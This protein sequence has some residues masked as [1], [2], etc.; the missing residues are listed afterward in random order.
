MKIRKEKQQNLRKKSYITISR[1]NFF[2]CI[3]RLFSS[4]EGGSARADHVSQRRCSHSTNSIIYISLWYNSLVTRIRRIL[5][6]CRFVGKMS[7]LY[8]KLNFSL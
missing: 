8:L 1:A 4:S 6:K 5:T 3:L 2:Y 7:N